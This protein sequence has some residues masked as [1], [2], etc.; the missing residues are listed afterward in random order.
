MQRQSSV[1]AIGPRDTS[2]L[3]RHLCF[4]LAAVSAFLVAVDFVAH[5]LS[6][7][8]REDSQADG[9]SGLVHPTSAGA[10]YDGMRS[11]LN[12]SAPPNRSEYGGHVTTGAVTAAHSMPDSA[13]ERPAM[14]T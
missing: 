14:A 5:D 11:E 8:D 13:F 2:T 7:L 4:A 6:G 10:T 3:V 1:Q 9:A 12:T